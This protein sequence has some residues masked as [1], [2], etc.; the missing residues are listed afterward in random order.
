MAPFILQ[1]L[2]AGAGTWICVP[3]GLIECCWAGLGKA[4]AF[5]KSRAAGTHNKKT[6]PGNPQNPGLLL[7]RSAQGEGSSPTALVKTGLR[8]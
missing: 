8:F 7:T 3:S 5:S 4:T 2:T 1:T 6:D